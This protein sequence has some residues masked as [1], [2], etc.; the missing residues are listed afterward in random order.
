ML[1]ELLEAWRTNNRINLFLLDHISATG[2][3]CTL[4]TRGG[5]EV[6]RQFGHMHD[7]RI[8]HLEKRAKDLSKG[9]SKFQSKRAET[10][11]PEKA[12]LKKAL[13]ASGRHRDVSRRRARRRAQTPWIQKGYFHQSQLLHR[14]RE[15]SPWQHSSHP[16]TERSQARQR[17]RVRNLGVGPDLGPRKVA[18]VESVLSVEVVSRQSNGI[19][20][21]LGSSFLGEY[22][23]PNP[24]HI[25]HFCVGVEGYEV[26]EVATKLEGAGIEPFV[27]QD[28]PEIYF[29]DPDGTRVQHSETD[30]RG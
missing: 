9:L 12:E 16:Q 19:N 1:D 8:Y 26:Q 15:S 6:A 5:R 13:A 20:L 11:I 21:G 30:Y 10:V 17:D 4:S 14:A 22:E 24:G 27:R 18:G 29:D 3:K 7:V 28:R 2:L 25:H 23:I